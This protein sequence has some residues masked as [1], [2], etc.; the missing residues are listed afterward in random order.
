MHVGEPE[1]SALKTVGQPG[2]IKAEQMEQGRIQIMN[3]DWLLDNVEPQIVRSP[4]DGSRL[5]SSP[6][7][8]H[9]KC[10]VVVVSTVIAPLNHRGPT[11][12]SSP[13]DNRVI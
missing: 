2:V 4:V 7:K 10:S 6:C 12:L 8:P 9:A 3:M 5:D 1:V 13:N 11:K